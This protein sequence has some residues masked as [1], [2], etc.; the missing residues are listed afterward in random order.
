MIKKRNF[1]MYSKYDSKLNFFL[2]ANAFDCF[3]KIN[4]SELCLNM[5]YT[6]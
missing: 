6:V 5:H 3:S 4:T 2:N 1:F